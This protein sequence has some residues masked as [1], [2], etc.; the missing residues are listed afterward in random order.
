MLGESLTFVF[1][2]KKPVIVVLVLR[3]RSRENKAQWRFVRRS[4]FRSIRRGRKDRVAAAEAAEA[5]AAEAAVGAAG[6]R[7]SLRKGNRYGKFRQSF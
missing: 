5:R 2:G 6:Q 3:G 1:K 7:S 4:Q